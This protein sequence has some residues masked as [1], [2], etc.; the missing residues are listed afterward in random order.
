[1]ATRRDEI[2]IPVLS[3]GEGYAAVAKPAGY[4]TVAER[5]RPGET[6]LL[7]A[8]AA[9]LAVPEVL[10]VHRLDRETSGI[11]LVAWTPE[12]HRALSLQFQRREVEKIYLAIVRGEVAREEFAIDAPLE[13]D[14]RGGSLMRIARPGRGRKSRTRFRVAER[15]RGF[16]LLEARPE[17]GRQHQIRVHLQHAGHPL[18]VDPPYGGG[19]GIFLSEIKRGYRPARDRSEAP[20]LGRV[21]LH[22]LALGFCDPASGE[23]VRLECPPPRD[24]ER[25][26]EALRRHAALRT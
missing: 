26:L 1:V 16:T 2:D 10:V 8:I 3:R 25:A 19:A 4:A 23:P 7:D 18:A 6:P 12:A 13:K 21:S 15:F 5:N 24:F 9:A 14:P 22:A 17:T 11:M 20:L